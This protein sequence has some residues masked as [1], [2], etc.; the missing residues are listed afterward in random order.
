[1]FGN[2]DEFRDDIIVLCK[3]NEIKIIED[4]ASGIGLH[5]NPKIKSDATIFSLAK[6]SIL[7]RAREG[8]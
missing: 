6:I 7:I 5:L 1:M 4:L 8:F 2:V 3:N